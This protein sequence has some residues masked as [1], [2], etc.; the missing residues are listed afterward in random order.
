MQSLNTVRELKTTFFHPPNELL[1]E[2]G[3][4]FGPIELVYETYGQ[5]NEDK[6]NAILVFHTLSGDAHAAGKHSM[7]DDDPGWWD[8]L[9]R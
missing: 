1:L 7:S 4:K 6:T 2:S 9:I 8:G 3:A 5:L